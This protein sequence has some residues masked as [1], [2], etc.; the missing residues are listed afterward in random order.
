LGS[1]TLFFSYDVDHQRF[2]QQAPEGPTLHFDAFG[3]HAELF[4]S[5]TSYDYLSA[6][7]TVT[8][9]YFH[10]DNL[11]SIAVI[12]DDSNHFEMRLNVA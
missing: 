4:G 8:T 5:V 2:K 11:G 9:R 7:R 12:T 10:T 6:G 1:S 3:V